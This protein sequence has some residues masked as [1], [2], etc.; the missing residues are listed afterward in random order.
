[1]APLSPLFAALAALLGALDG[2]ARLFMSP[3]HNIQYTTSELEEAS[4]QC[5]DVSQFVVTF[6]FTTYVH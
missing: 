5:T 3:S 6:Q 1:M 2:A 4:C